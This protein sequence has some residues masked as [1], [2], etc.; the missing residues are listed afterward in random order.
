MGG[1]PAARKQILVVFPTAWDAAQLASCRAGW[2][3]RYEITFAGPADADCP[4]DFDALEFIE[5]T[6]ETWRGRIDGVLS[7]SDYPGA[8]VAGAIATRLDLPGSRPERLLRCAHKYQAR[9][10]LAEAVPEATPAFALLDPD[11]PDGG[12]PDL[13]FPCFVKPVKGAFSIFSERLDSL[14]ELG[15]F[16]ERP[17]VREFTAEHPRIFDA[18]VA[19]YT[20]FEFGGGYFLAEELLHGAQVTLEGFVRD[21]RVE[22]LGIV[23]SVM[24][25]GTRSFAR[26]EYPSALPRAVQ[27]RMAE[28]ASR[29]VVHLGLESTC[30]N[31]EM[32]HDPATGGIHV[33]EVNPRLCGQFADLY[34]K[35]DGTHGYEVALAVAAGEAPRLRRREGENAAAAS[36]P[37]R[38]FEAVRVARAPDPATLH[39]A[40]ALFPG[41]LV[42]SEAETGQR[43]DDFETVEDGQSIRYAVVNL[44]GSDR[45]ELRRRLEAVTARLG[46]AFTRIG[47]PLAR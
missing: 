7:S 3:G 9:R 24:H 36:F 31:I 35:V 23:D 26:F 27:E 16:L 32:I 1:G 19:R 40:Q 42:W 41:T 5:R 18:L 22:V 46:F 47:S 38:V 43:L 11:K 21:G 2:E 37:L 12:C 14:D 10:A 6:A 28:I 17:A 8:A 33:I 30:F 15:A 4:A 20:D 44:G 34:Q 39:S 13:F 29:A 45:A 25:P